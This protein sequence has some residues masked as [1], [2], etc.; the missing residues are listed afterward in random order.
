VP[1]TLAR[2][3]VNEEN[4]E[5]TTNENATRV[6]LVGYNGANNTGAEALLLA[7]I[8]DVRAVLGP[9]TL[10]TVPTLAPENLRRYVQESATLKIVPIPIL[11]F[12]ALKRLVSEADIVMLVEGSTYMDTWG[13]VLLW[14]FLWSSYWA[15]RLGKKCI[16][17][18]VDAGALSALN[19]RLVRT[20]ASRTDLI[21]TRNQSAARRLA[22]YGVTAP[23]ES[24]A[25][26]A[27]TYIT[28]PQDEGWVERE[29]PQARK[30]MVGMAVVDFN[31]F[32]V[33]MRPFG[34][35]ADCYKW[36]YYFSRSSRRRRASEELSEGYAAIADDIVAERGLP[37]AFICMEQLDES[38]AAAIQQRMKRPEMS[39][40]FSARRHNASQMTVLLR[41][42][43]LL[44]T[45][46]YHAGVLSLA[47]RVPQIA[48]G[49][50]LRLRTLYEDLGL[51]E[52]FFID[53]RSPR[54][55]QRLTTCIRSLLDDPG[56]VGKTLDV[57]YA[58]HLARARRN[59]ALLA[60]ELGVIT[61]VVR[62]AA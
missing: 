1:P 2:Y 28:R 57:G 30:G 46:R 61:T 9:D 26:N 5:V 49:H 51:L 12:G 47:A 15:A 54:M 31:L 35:K 55:L 10:I 56:Q 43:R 11:Y 23:I 45:S 40:I 14:A 3:R 4:S 32:P 36:P 59:Q 41:G 29:W 48:V 7:D 19:Q 42:L 18:A 60:R 39:R 62:G 53:P 52:R 34:K 24:T 22:A 58:D 44:V 33:V 8:E 38:L 13:S 16:A 21:V 27:F 50:D 17:Y 25:D 6:L 20:V 37:V